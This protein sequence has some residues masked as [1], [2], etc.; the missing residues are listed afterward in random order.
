[1]AVVAEL[2]RHRHER[3]ALDLV[4]DNVVLQ[5]LPVNA[6][7]VALNEPVEDAAYRAQ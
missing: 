6:Q 7:G 2:L 1:V 5:L 4:A 3:I